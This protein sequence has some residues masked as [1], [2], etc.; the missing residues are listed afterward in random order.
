[1]KK[2]IWSPCWDFFYARFWSTEPNK[3]AQFI[4]F[5]KRNKDLEMCTWPNDMTKC[6]CTVHFLHFILTSGCFVHCWNKLNNFQSCTC[7][8]L[9]A[10][11]Q[12]NQKKKTASPSRHFIL[13]FS[14][15][16]CLCFGFQPSHVRSK[17]GPW[18]LNTFQHPPHIIT[19]Y[20][21]SGEKM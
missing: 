19:S 13:F 2:P 11:W 7:K 14:S 10:E 1:M 20:V 15:S 12:I 16:V 4:I 17:L 18:P 5:S 21:Q 6:T 3:P 9:T 8:T